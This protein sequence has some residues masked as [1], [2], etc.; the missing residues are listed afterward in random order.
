MYKTIIF[1]FDGTLVDCK[2]LHQDGFR[3]AATKVINNLNY[4]DEDLEGIPTQE[5]IKYFKGLGYKFDAELLTNL[6]IQHTNEN[7]E[8]YIQFDQELYD[9]IHKLKTKYELCLASNATYD[10]LIKSLN[11]LNIL[12]CFEKVNSS[13]NFVAKPEP[14]MFLD[15]IK[16][17]K[18]QTLIF[19]DSEVGLQAAHAS[20]C[21]VC[22]VENSLQTRSEIRKLLE[23]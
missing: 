3:Y 2:K 20:G 18:Q 11:I 16:Y 1:D 17:T 21:A 9:L 10:Y 5:K 12:D 7:I 13:S 6:K 4:K 14:G 22:S 19:E 23:I 15:C 8:K